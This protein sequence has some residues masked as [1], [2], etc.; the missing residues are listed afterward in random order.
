MEGPSPETKWVLTKREHFEFIKKV[1]PDVVP[2]DTLGPLAS[3][4]VFTLLLHWYHC[5]L[6][7][8]QKIS[9]I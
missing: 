2:V 8:T 4:E 1:T 5:S 6:R 9:K 3:G 7:V